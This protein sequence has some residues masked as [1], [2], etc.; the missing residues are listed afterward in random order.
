MQARG[1]FIGD[2]WARSALDKAVSVAVE[3]IDLQT[4]PTNERSFMMLY[5]D[6]NRLVVEFLTTKSKWPKV[7]PRLWAYMIEFHC[8]ETNEVLLTREGMIDRVKAS[9]R[10]VDGVLGELVRF[11]ALTTLR[12]P[13]V[14]RRGRRRAVFSESE[15]W[16][17]VSRGEARRG[18]GA[19]SQARFGCVGG[20]D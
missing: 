3:V 11:H 7:G 14:G 4:A 17:R 15:S 13:T 6:Q 9:P 8:R 1:L 5:P 10:A 2:D 16:E 18:A 20:A 19:C 12:V